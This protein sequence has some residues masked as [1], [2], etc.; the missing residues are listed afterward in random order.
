MQELEKAIEN[1]VVRWAKKSHIK[2]RKKVMGELLDRWFFLPNGYLL[3]IEFKRLGEK[4]F[5]RQQYEIDELKEL[6]YD[7]QVH[8]NSEEAIKAIQEAM[9]RCRSQ[10]PKEGRKVWVTAKRSGVLPRPRT[11]KNKHKPS[12]NKNTAKGK[13]DR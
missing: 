9:G 3:I 6:G 2:M 10:V 13:A 11:G 4:P 5:A 12:D 1:R 8:D 7:V